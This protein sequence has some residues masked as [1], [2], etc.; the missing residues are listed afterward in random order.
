MDS[1][2]LSNLVLNINRI[3][4]NNEIFDNYQWVFVIF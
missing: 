2:S 1:L 4:L 3:N